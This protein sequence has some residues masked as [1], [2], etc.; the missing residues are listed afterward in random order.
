[1]CVVCVYLC[2]DYVFVC[3]KGCLHRVEEGSE[4]EGVGN[5]DY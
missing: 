5:S 2:V 3:V 4:S 1:M